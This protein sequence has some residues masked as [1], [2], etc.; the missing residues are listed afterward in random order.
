MVRR[1]RSRRDDVGVA[2]R[3]VVRVLAVEP[4]EERRVSI[5]VI[6]I[7]EQRVAVGLRQV[8][9]GLELRDRR[10]DLDR[11]LLVADRRLDRIWRP[12]D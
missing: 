7:L 11:R 1:C 3:D 2:L 12:C 6:E 8:F 5:E 10:G 9:V 4:V